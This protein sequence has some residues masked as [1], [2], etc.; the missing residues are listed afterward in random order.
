MGFIYG[1]S[2][3]SNFGTTPNLFWIEDLAQF[4]PVDIQRGIEQCRRSNSPFPPNLG[5]F[6]AYCT[7]P[8][9]EDVYK[10]ERETRE[11]Y[12]LPKPKASETVRQ[13]AMA[14]IRKELKILATPTTSKEALEQRQAAMIQ[15]AENLIEQQEVKV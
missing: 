6:L 13:A 11:R 9:V 4:S 8:I 10:Q 3:T 2:F 15:A 1:N 14:Q 5:Q 7:P 12:L